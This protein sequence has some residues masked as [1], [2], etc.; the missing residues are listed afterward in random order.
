MQSHAM[1]AMM[2]AVAQPPSENF[3]ITSIT[4]ILM[5][6]I[7]PRSNRKK[8]LIHDSSS[9]RCCHQYKH[10]PNRKI[11]NVRKTEIEYRTISN[12]TLPRVQNRIASAA[13]RRGHHVT[14]A[15]ILQFSHNSGMRCRDGGIGRRTG[16]KIPRWRQRA[17]SIP[18][19]GTKNMFYTVSSSLKTR[20]LHRHT[21]FL[22]SQAIAPDNMALQRNTVIFV[23][24]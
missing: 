14:I 18:A 6:I 5:Q 23:G 11:A 22:L 19:L 4:R 7:K 17:G 13:I 21:G 9:L 24:I 1:A 2:S 20:M 3:S 8:R 10:K 16:L 12:V 15:S